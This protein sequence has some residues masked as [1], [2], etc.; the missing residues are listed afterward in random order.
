M[1]PVE[2]GICEIYRQDRVVGLGFAVDAT[3]VVTCAHVVNT[4]LG[5]NDRLESGRPDPDDSLRVRFPIGGAHDDD[6]FRSASVAGWLP[7]SH[8]TFEAE[9]VAVL[10]FSIPAPAHVPTL[11]PLRHRGSMSVQMWGPQVDR[12]DGGHVKGELL[13]EVR[14]GRVQI[15]AGGGPFRVR[16][17][18][19]GGP[20]WETSTGG[21][22]GVLS[23]CGAES[24][25]VD[26]YLL[27]V[28]RIAAAWPQWLAASRD[29]NERPGRAAPD[30]LDRVAEAARHHP[31]FADADIRRV[32]A[33]A[34]RDG[35]LLATV[36]V[37]FGGRVFGAARQPIGALA[38]DVTADEV[39][40]FAA[41]VRTY[42]DAGDG[43]TGGTLVYTGRP[44][45]AALRD[46]AGR[47]SIDLRSLVEFQTGI[48]LRPFAERQHAEIAA[49]ERY[50]GRGY[51]PQRF[52]EPPDATIADQPLVDALLGWL[53]EPEGHLVVILAPFGHG[54]TYLLHE[55]ARQVHERPDYPAVPVLVRLRDLE[56]NH[57]I[58]ELVA[59]QLT[60]AGERRVD[61]D[62]LAYLRREGRVVLLFD[63]FDE[64]A[65]RITYDQAGAHLA[66]I[67]RAAEGRAK[68]VLTS[69]REYFL[70]GGDV[71]AA[72]GRRLDTLADRRIVEIADFDRDQIRTFL[73]ARL[74]TEAA[75]RF[76][77]VLTDSGLLELA[78]NP[79]MLALLSGIGEDTIA[80]ARDA[81]GSATT[82]WVFEQVLSG[83]L[84][85]E[86]DR[87]HPGGTSPKPWVSAL[88]K[89]LTA[90]AV[91]LW[92]SGGTSLSPAD[93]EEQAGILT[94]LE[95]TERL[96][97]DQAVHVLGSGSLLIS[98][99]DAR[100]DFVHRSLMEW[101]VVNEIA[102][103]MPHG[104]GD[105]EELARLTA[106]PLSPLQIDL[107]AE[108]AGLETL[109]DWARRA[110]KDADERVRDNALAATRQRDLTL[111]EAL[112]LSGQD[113]RGR[114]LTGAD[115]AGADLVR[116]D[117]TE[118][119]LEGADLRGAD[120]TGAK[121]TRA[122]LD[123]ADLSGA[124][125]DQADL[126]DARLLGADLRS[127]QW[128]G[129]ASALRATTIGA[130][131][132]GAALDA[133]VA[134][135]A[136]T[137]DQAIVLR[138]PGESL[139]GARA[140]CI[141][142]SGQLAGVVCGTNIQIW[143]L[144]TARPVLTMS[145]H[146]D[147]VT[148]AAWSPDGRYLASSSIDETA[149]IWN[150]ST[151]RSILVLSGHTH[152]VQAV[153]W[154]PDG[155]QL[156]TCGLDG[157][158]RVWKAGTGQ[159]V[160]TI[161]DGPYI[162][163][164]TWSP[165]GRH[166]A[167]VVA[168]ASLRI[169][170]ADTGELVRTLEG[171]SGHLAML[172]WSTDGRYLAAGDDR[173]I[174]IW[175]ADT[176]ARVRALTGHASRVSLV[177]WSPDG[178]H[179]A[180]VASL[181]RTRVWDVPT[182]AQVSEIREAYDAFALAWMPD[183]SGLATIESAGHHERVCVWDSRMGEQ[184]RTV[185]TRFHPMRSV[186]WSPDGARLVAGAG[187]GS[188]FIWDAVGGD[189]LQ[190][191]GSSDENGSVAFSPDG[192][193][194]AFATG[195]REARI[196]DIAA[197]E[198]VRTLESP[199]NRATIGVQAA[200]AWSPDGRWIAFGSNGGT[201]CVWD[202]ATARLARTLANQSYPVTDLSWSPDGR[203][204]A[205]GGSGEVR[206]W[207]ADSGALTRT[208]TMDSISAVAWSPDS[209]RI[210]AAGR[211]VRI[212][213]TDTGA[214][215][216][217][218]TDRTGSVTSISWAP[219]GGQ[220]AAGGDDQTIRIWDTHYGIVTSTL[221]T[222]CP[223][224]AVAWSPNG[225]RLAV[226]LANGTVQ[227]WE[228]DSRVLQATL[229]PLGEGWA[230]LQDAHHF[231]YQGTLRGEFWWTVGLSRFE[232]GELDAYIPGKQSVT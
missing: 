55:L 101:L 62:R 108:I 24:D 183:G 67:L 229:V 65:R 230:V 178:Q 43:V 154:S 153:A 87:S 16:P 179:L 82:A 109:T 202:T 212:W 64:L 160:Q 136:T 37:R 148:A 207:R 59:A 57:D 210:A 56:K 208:F 146:T 137:P 113:L 40:S 74:D 49:D 143:H 4:A 190:R 22:V 36:E 112:N 177:A 205:G 158:V 111:S 14:G 171:D 209:R 51:V 98:V 21:V 69:R 138:T 219:D 124:I 117:L 95:D 182:G 23:A 170:K 39:T 191:F 110:A 52:T 18:F 174:Q 162:D 157:T 84:T 17:G 206:V 75:D 172:A 71:Q 90:L 232:I 125:L 96:E 35:H 68:V 92:S 215:E 120:L 63:G 94:E 47:S 197:A 93:L 223:V 119:V 28:D 198:E 6:L 133:L 231:G 79:R 32:D 60:R 102:A 78:A 73:S 99:G 189:L 181:D 184:L 128:A 34:G 38:G 131:V 45:S 8:G 203:H 11:H 204:L 27:S 192:R 151:G 13:G 12:R 103:R 213:A 10:E 42:R 104:G 15:N 25:A 194:L 147:R 193:R 53:A 48:D 7:A 186:E 176:G 224:S 220:L 33:D 19:S 31:D 126:R 168:R 97:R 81:Q 5:R 86:Y 91:R 214:L 156:A 80:A 2:Y 61:L 72:F 107:L 130:R 226:G 150:A 196:L 88:R 164:V 100:F 200:V 41:I 134:G 149:R 76:M 175:E 139:W 217:T 129:L 121:L 216:W 161:A 3:H 50:P 163:S 159:L 106:R 211:D 83:W 66:T 225:K 54:K 44:A 165:D 140:L 116:A 20:V 155:R 199:T 122:R 123:R 85:G 141:D 89:A 144:G 1:S 180:S 58:D 132:D 227:L 152:W 46:L 105:P 145:G 187:D 29:E 135:G 114:D 195:V 70:T 218:L 167:A 118:A 185:G 169:W 201:L 142:G 166:L 115:L 30:L 222:Y 188:R 221:T 26:A 127:V 228:P 173:V 9:D 77:S